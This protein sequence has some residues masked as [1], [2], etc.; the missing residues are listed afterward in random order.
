MRRRLG[1]LALTLLSGCAG[2]AAED[3][4]PPAEVR[5]R[6]GE[7]TIAIVQ[8]AT[9]VEVFRIDGR[10]YLDPKKEVGK[11]D[12]RFGGYAVTATG[13]EQGEKFAAAAA[14]VLLDGKNYDFVGAKGCKFDPGVGLRFWKGKESAD[15][16][17]C[18][19]CNELKVTAPDPEKQGVKSPY[20]DFD[21]GRAAFV[22]LAQE[23]FP[24]DKDIQGLKVRE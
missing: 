15:V 2:A 19:R 7:Q 20:A 8:G 4:G 12:K 22:K 9:R 10:D 17:V 18:Y 14:K 6:F 24:D 16:V 1:V 5:E 21:P 3:K 11:Q 13:K 23:A